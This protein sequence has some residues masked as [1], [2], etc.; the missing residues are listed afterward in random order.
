MVHQ[1]RGDGNVALVA[2]VADQ[3]R[4]LSLAR[5]SR[6]RA[7]LLI[8]ATERLSVIVRLC[9][10]SHEW[11]AVETVRERMTTLVASALLLRGEQ[12]QPRGRRVPEARDGGPRDGGEA[13]GTLPAC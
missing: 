3:H 2:H 1:Q 4:C 10:A 7:R 12:P 13:C 6:V 5:R 8:A 9:E 11:E